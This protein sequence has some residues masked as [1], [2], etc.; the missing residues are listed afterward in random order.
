[1]GADAPMPSKVRIRSGIL[2]GLSSHEIQIEY[3]GKPIRCSRYNPLGHSNSPCR[4]VKNY[5]PTGRVLKAPLHQSPHGASSKT[6]SLPRIPKATKRTKS[7]D[8]GTGHITC[9]NTFGA[10]H[11]LGDECPL[12]ICLEASN[13]GRVKDKSLQVLS[14]PC[15][16]DTLKPGIE[17]CHVPEA[18]SEAHLSGDQMIEMLPV[19]RDNPTRV[20]SG[21]DLGHSFARPEL[22]TPNPNYSCF[23]INKLLKSRGSRRL[24]SA[25]TTATPEIPQPKDLSSI[26]TRT[27]VISNLPSSDACAGS[28]LKVSILEKLW[29]SSLV[30]WY[31][32]VPVWT[33]LSLLTAGLELLDG[34]LFDMPV[35][36]LM[37]VW[38][39]WPF[40]PSVSRFGRTVAWYA[41]ICLNCVLSCAG[42]LHNAG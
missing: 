21:T 7:M 28:L 31:G 19:N 39:T 36:V 4:S 41:S 40:L 18:R 33:Q 5:G 29:A 8:S 11:D 24:G 6:G 23:N 1:M 15:S 34:M 17:D 22:A 30:A 2:E 20:T 37:S 38:S 32:L 27:A 16:L 42:M 3:Q 25:L 35:C 13:K 26:E 14:P 12:V 9:P 10:L